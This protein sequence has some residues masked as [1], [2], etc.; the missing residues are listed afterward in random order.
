MPDTQK[1]GSEMCLFAI[2]AFLIIFG[3]IALLFFGS[4]KSDGISFP[5]M[6]F[7]FVIILYLL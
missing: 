6:L 4:V 5:I 2:N 1:K 3:I 7:L